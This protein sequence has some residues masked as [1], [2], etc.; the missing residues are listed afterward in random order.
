MQML[1]MVKSTKS[2][3]K[4]TFPIVCRPV[5]LFGVFP[6]TTAREP[7]DMV[8]ANHGLWGIIS[9]FSD[10]VRHVSIPCEVRETIAKPDLL[11]RLFVCILILGVCPIT[12]VHFVVS[13]KHFKALKRPQSC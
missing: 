8:H 4:T 13:I 10:N 2:A 12:K 3:M 9:T 1:K 7:V 6:R 11:R 5:N